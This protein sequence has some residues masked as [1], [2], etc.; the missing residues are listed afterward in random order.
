M[1][2]G[3]KILCKKDYFVDR[4]SGFSLY[5]VKLF[6]CGDF[7]EVISF[8]ENYIVVKTNAD[9]ISEN[10]TFFWYSGDSKYIWDWFYTEKEIRKMKLNKLEMYEIQ[11][12]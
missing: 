7:Y 11:K 3:N 10:H 8:T 4:N 9:P 5:K 12:R 1:K 6:K 2:K